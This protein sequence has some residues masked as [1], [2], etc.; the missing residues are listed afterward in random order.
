MQTP[1]DL[2]NEEY[3]QRKG[4][5]PNYSLRS[6][7]KWLQFSPAQVSQMMAGK[8]PITLN[9]QKKINDRLGLSP[10]QSQEMIKGLLMQKNLIS[11]EPAK[12]NRLLKDDQ[13]HLVSDWYHLAILSL[14]KVKGAS[15]DPRW[16][17]RRL[18]IKSEEAHH[19]L[20]RLERLG[21]LQIKPIFK[22][23]GEPFEA[24]SDVPSAAIRKYHK[25]NLSLAL[26]KIE[27]VPLKLRQFQSISVPLHPS[28]VKNLKDEIDSFLNRASELCANCKATEVYHLNV[29][30][31]PVTQIADSIAQEPKC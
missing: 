16:I 23:I 11:A 22:Q 15:A 25:Q 24:V 20:Q 7:A 9:S 8:R 10:S 12:Q 6:F 5:N 3:K 2:L 13:F 1:K 28:L 4:R 31:F 17:A 27:T 14:T 30:L 29:Q 21:I 26:E 19:A 18:G